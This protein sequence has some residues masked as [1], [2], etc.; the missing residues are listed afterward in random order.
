MG[1]IKPRVTEI[2]QIFGKILSFKEDETI[3][4]G[5]VTLPI[6]DLLPILCIELARIANKHEE[7]AEG[8][9]DWIAE[10]ILYMKGDVD[11]LP[12]MDYGYFI[13]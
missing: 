13:D 12:K 8:L 10:G 6:N 1:L 3:S 2:F 5:S 11:Q 4:L 9:F 7:Q